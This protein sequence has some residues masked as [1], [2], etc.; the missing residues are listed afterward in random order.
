MTSLLSSAIE[1]LNDND[2]IS[3]ANL[4]E[5]GLPGGGTLRYTDY[6]RD[7]T[8]DGATYTAGVIKNIGNIRQTKD[9]TVYD[10]SVTLTGLNSTE[11]SRAMNSDVNLNRPV[12]IHTAILDSTDKPIQL[13][14]E[15]T[16][17]TKFKGVLSGVSV[18]DTTS[19][20]SMGSSSITWTCSSQLKNFNRVNGRITDDTSHRGLVNVGGI[21]VPSSSAK[22]L[23]YQTDKG[24]YHAGQ[25]INVLAQYQVKEKRYVLKSK[26]ASG[27]GGLLGA[28]KYSTKE[29]WETVTKEVD[30]DINLTTKYIPVLYGVQRTPGIPIFVDTHVEKPSEVWAVYAFCEGE[31]DGFLDFYLDDNPMICVNDEDN[32]A[33]LC[34]GRKRIAGD[35][36]SIATNVNG[37]PPGTRTGTSIHGEKY[38]YNDGNGDIDFWVYHGKT[39]QTANQ[40]LVDLAAN[41]KFKLQQIKGMGPEYWDGTFK[42]VDTAYVVMRYTMNSNRTNMPSLEAEV[43]GRKIPV[44]DTSGNLVSSNKTSL[45]FAW[46]TFDYLNNSVFGAGIPVSD[47]PIKDFAEAAAIMDIQDTSYQYTWVPFWRYIGWTTYENSN[48]AFLQGSALI[49]TSTEVFKNVQALLTQADCSLN[50]VNGKYLYNIEAARTPVAD[51][52]IGH[53]KEGTFTYS[54]TDTNGKFNS[55]Q[56]AMIDPAK[57]W[58]TNTVTFYDSNYLTEDNNIENKGNVTF[59][60]ITNYYTAR[61]RAERKL[62]QSRLIKTISFSLPYKFLGLHPNNVIT[63]THPRY[64]WDKKKFLIRDIQE[65]RMGELTVTCN[66]YEDSVY[67]NSDQV[68]N[69][70]DQNTIPTVNVLPPRNLVYTPENNSEYVG[71]QGI[72]SWDTSLSAGVTS[73]TIRRTGTTIIDSVAVDEDSETSFEYPVI[74]LEPNMYTFEVR[75]VNFEG[76]TSA[77]ATL[78]VYIDPS[79][80]LPNITNFICV[81][82]DSE[83]IFVTG[84]VQLQWD[85]ISTTQNNLVYRLQ[86]LEGSTILRDITTTATSFVY[87]FQFNKDDYA[88]ANSGALGVYRTISFRIRAEADA[89]AQSVSWVTL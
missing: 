82:A 42:L 73:Y 5:L 9:L 15:S 44:Y 2:T 36:I 81:N 53:T 77:P 24:F 52:D 86:V 48:R 83:G 21:L 55:I 74:G 14:Q 58:N 69:S 6:R 26:R 10:V 66:E 7:L 60:Y 8:I 3:I 68:D 41:N 76:R 70:D 54:N 29:V 16:Y 12:A 89:G 49:D 32:D 56:A 57:S 22:K 31:I 46:Q 51:I 50:M 64:G 40:Q 65:N 1:F 19:T 79:V 47:L 61:S 45:N 88:T 84:D 4:V 63:F 39:G 13:T 25:S 23:E 11:L 27:L 71:L 37:T 18:K 85:A 72:L 78:E 67:I 20:T 35:T 34:L 43:Q 33:R 75:A 59:P 38:T 62:R 87:T 30:M 80:N 28:R 17:Y